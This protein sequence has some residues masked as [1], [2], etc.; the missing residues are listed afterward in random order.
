M[1]RVNQIIIKTL[2]LFLLLPTILSGQEEKKEDVWEPFKFF[3]GLWKGTGEGEPGKSKLEAEF[4]FVLNGRFLEV[5]GKAVFEPQEKNQKGEVHQDWGLFSYD[6]I[7]GKFVLRQFHVEGFVNQYVLDTLSSDGK[8][9][10]FLS[11]S[12][13]N[14]PSGWKAK[15]TYKILNEDEFLLVFELAAPG[16]DLEC[17]SQN[18]LKRK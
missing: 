3:V 2:F 11:E 13:E 1:C 18:H 5:K 15:V 17:Y 8:T 10:V 6:R 9:F 7:R 4:K 12:I 16:K 14:I